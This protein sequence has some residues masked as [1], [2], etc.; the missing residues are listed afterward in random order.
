MDAG[1]SILIKAEQEAFVRSSLVELNLSRRSLLT[2]L[3]VIHK[4]DPDP[5]HRAQTSSHV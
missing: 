4:N 2:I 5:L 3:P 1:P